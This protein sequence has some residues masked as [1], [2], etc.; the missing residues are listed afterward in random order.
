MPYASSATTTLDQRPGDGADL[1]D[2]LLTFAA[3]RILNDDDVGDYTIGRWR[4]A[5]GSA[6]RRCATRKA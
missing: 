2:H 5:P 3:G 6:R 4:I 1:S